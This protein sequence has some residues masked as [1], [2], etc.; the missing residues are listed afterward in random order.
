MEAII[1]MPY[2]YGLDGSGATEG[3]VSGFNSTENLNI[4]LSGASDL[5]LT[6][7]SAG[8][9]SCTLSGASTL[10]LRDVKTND[11]D[12]SLAGASDLLGNLTAADTGFILSGASTV[13][14]QGSGNDLK[15]DAVGAS[16]IELVDF[17]VHNA[18]ITLSGG[19]E[20]EITA[21]GTLDIEASGAS[22]LTYYGEP[23]I[24]SIDIG[25]GSEVIKKGADGGG[26]LSTP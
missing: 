8:D 18:D 14:L 4:Q 2:F 1:T 11:A 3:V 13:R 9:L 10:K 22:E 23:S 26:R 20:C 15:I 7:I 6:D 16:D 19:S 5:V 25:G 17:P 12:F 24:S 21:E